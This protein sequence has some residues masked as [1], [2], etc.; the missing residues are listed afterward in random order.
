MRRRT[1]GLRR[2]EV[3][4][5]AHISTNF[6]TRL[7]QRR[8]SRPSVQT[9]CALARAPRLTQDEREHLCALVGHIAPPRAFRIE[10]ASPKLLTVLD[11]LNTPAQTVSGLGVML[12]QNRLAQPLIGVQT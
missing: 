11:R 2:E 7:K 6:Y 10:H 5:H 9:T 3:A 8:G 1:R 12:S 4:G